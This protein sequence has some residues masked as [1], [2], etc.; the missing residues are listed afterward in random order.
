M[1]KTALA[2]D[3]R[4]HEIPMTLNSHLALKAA[5]KTA[6]ASEVDQKFIAAALTI[7]EYATINEN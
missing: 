4:S 6:Q 7:K 3:L 2:P 1:R 5:I